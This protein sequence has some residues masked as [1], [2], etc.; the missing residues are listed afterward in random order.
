VV[1]RKKFFHLKLLETLFCSAYSVKAPDILPWGAK[2]VPVSMLTFCWN[3]QNGGGP[4]VVDGVGED[5]EGFN[6]VF[7]AVVRGDARGVVP[8]WRICCAQVNRVP[9]A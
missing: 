8:D 9:T 3:C 1:L 6:P 4:V 5:C 7:E 2:R